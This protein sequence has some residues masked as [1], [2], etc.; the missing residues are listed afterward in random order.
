MFKKSLFLCS[1]FL[2]KNGHDFL[3]TQVDWVLIT[4]HNQTLRQMYT[5]MHIARKKLR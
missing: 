1:E 5:L 2:H 4:A 3:D